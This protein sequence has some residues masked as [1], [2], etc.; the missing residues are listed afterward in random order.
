MRTCVLFLLVVSSAMAAE[1][2]FTSSATVKPV[3]KSTV[4]QIPY[5]TWGAD[6]AGFVANGNSLR[7]KPGSVYNKLGLDLQFVNGDNFPQQVDNYLSGKTPYIRGEVRQLGIASEALNKSPD[8][9]PVVILQLSFSLGDHIVGREKVKTL[10][11]LKGAK[12]CLQRGGPHLGLLQDTLEAAAITWDDITIVW[13]DDLTGPNGPAAKFKADESIDCCC[14]I[15][16]DMIGLCSA[17]DQK[18]TGKDDTVLGAHVVNSTSTMSRSVVDVWAVR[19]DYFKS[20][21]EEVGK[22]VA[23]YLKGTVELVRQRNSFQNEDKGSFTKGTGPAYK[24]ALTHAQTVFGK[25]VIQSLENEGHGLLLDAEFAGLPGQ[26]SFF[27]DKGNLNNFESK[28]RKAL[29][30]AVSRGYASA[31]LGF[32]VANWDYKAMALLADVE[33]KE[34]KITGRVQAESLDINPDQV[35]DDK[36]IDT[37]T[38]NFSDNATEFSSDEHGATFKRAIEW[39]AT[40]GQGVVQIRGHAD[41]NAVLASVVRAGLKKGIIKRNG[42]KAPYTYYMNGKVL[43]LSQTKELINLIN[44]DAF[45]GTDENPREVLQAALNLS[46]ARANAVKEALQKYAKELGVNLDATQIQPVGVGISQPLIAR[47]SGPKDSLKNM[48]VEFS[49]IKVSAEAVKPSDYDF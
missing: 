13:V 37:I 46:Q 45:A 43:D 25:D 16:P 10:K 5:L 18:G 11:D 1:P 9:K 39:S 35:I 28:Q 36:V 44:S 23:G 3:V 17:I 31:R 19:S 33:Y 38:I 21:R 2:R 49:I 42:N 32:A 26:I 22:F 30:L 12:I 29:D 7:T 41:T 34:P 24:A 47:P 15:T 6:V 4:T 8:T 20:N 40:F 48:R 14:V 27:K